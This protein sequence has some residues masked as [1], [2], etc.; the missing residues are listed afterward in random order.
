MKTVCKVALVF[1]MV[2][3]LRLMAA[4]QA[5]SSP[6]QGK[7]LGDL[8]REIRAKRQAQNGSPA[9][10]VA[11]QGEARP[12]SEGIPALTGADFAAL[13][14]VADRARA[15]KERIGGGAWR[16]YTFYDSVSHPAEGDNATD[17][18]W[19]LHIATLQKWVA[20]RPESITARVALA[21]GYR[22]RAW[23]LRGKGAAKT[24]TADRWQE[25]KAEI[26]KAFSTLVD[27]EKLPAKCP[28]WYFV[29]LE[30][31]RDQDWDKER[32]RA[33][34]ER[35]IAF[36]PA[37]YHS[38][39]EYANNLLPKNHGAPGEAEAF[40]EESARRIGGRQ[41]SFVYFEIATV[42]YCM[43]FDETAR[44][45]MSWPTIKEG[46]AEVEQRYGATPLKLNRYLLLAYLYRDVDVARRVLE[47]LGD[48]WDPS[49]WRKQD[50]F[51]KVRTWAGLLRV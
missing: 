49:I 11:G 5:S 27:A 41:G 2:C 43:C 9:P 7:S 23:K 39:R 25:F 35:S 38:Y 18:Q 12:Q 1:L 30:I 51:N 3:P 20:A 14:A 42:I 33:L 4:P 45:T 50:S 29:M 10:V 26:D 13:D 24:V 16:L 36:E 15:S 21:E 31:A 8:A 28:H 17:E 40:A 6:N 47:Q 32:T 22:F 34:F 19:A 48:Q 46:F 37:Y 44:P